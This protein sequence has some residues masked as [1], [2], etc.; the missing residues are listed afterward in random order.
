M[1]L[2]V[3]QFICREDNFA[4]ILHD[5]SRGITWA[6]DAP[7]AAAMLDVLQARGWGLDFLLITHH[8]G[9]HTAGIGEIK[10]QTVAKIVGPLR[11]ADKI[12]GLDIVVDEGD[13]LDFGAS[14]IE[15][16]STP[17]HTAGAVSYH[18]PQEG[19]VF[20]GDTLFSLGCGRL[21]ECPAEIM[22]SSLKKLQQL[23][24]ETNLYCGHEYTK[25]NGRFALSV[26]G[27]NEALKTRLLE[28]DEYYACGQPALPSTIGQELLT[29]PFLR[30]DDPHIRTHLGLPDSDD[31]T[32]FAEI[33]R[34]K[35]I[36]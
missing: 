14:V 12:D 22:F 6:I 3:E 26:D 16:L 27:A 31:V 11:E 18:M 20:T 5:E 32:V 29:N 9:D 33:R 34:R 10:R 35:D 36:F 30:Y 24:P 19:H 1:P 25:N 17:G 21:F 8:H 4:V 7:D 2:V 13:R 15:V 28:V 23:P